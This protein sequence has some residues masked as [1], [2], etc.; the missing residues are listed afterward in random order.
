MVQVLISIGERTN[1]QQVPVAVG[2]VRRCDALCR[3]CPCTEADQLA[4][5]LACRYSD[6][7]HDM[8]RRRQ[9]NDG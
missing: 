2:E 6:V 3:G 5:Q 4:R 9:H 8:I 1:L 7:L